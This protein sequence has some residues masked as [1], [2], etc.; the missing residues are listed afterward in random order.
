M[1]LAFMLLATSPLSPSWSSQILAVATAVSS[2]LH[3]L[4]QQNNIA[5]TRRRLRFPT[6]CIAGSSNWRHWFQQKETTV[7]AKICDVTTKTI[8][9]PSETHHRFQQK[10]TTAVAKTPLVPASHCSFFNG[11]LK[12]KK[13]DGCH[14]NTHSQWSA[15]CG[16][17]L[18]IGG[19]GASRG[20]APGCSLFL[21]WL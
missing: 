20:A 12:H 1:F 11:W 18:S 17:S 8:A 7:P 15:G 3:R 10:I 6:N 19:D 13:C 9:G 4:L 14:C 16:F 2:K 21:R 5:A